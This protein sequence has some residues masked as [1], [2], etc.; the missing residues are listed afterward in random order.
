MKIGI[1][2]NEVLRDFLGQ[3]VYT[4]EKYIGEVDLKREDIKSTDLMEFFDFETIDGLNKFLFDEAALEIFG[5]A[6]QMSDNLMDKFNLFL[7]DIK[8][9]EEHEIEIVSREAMKSIPSTFFFLSK[10]SCKID[11][12][13]FIVDYDKYWD[14]VDVLITADPRALEVKPEGKMS[15]KINAP[16]N[17]G[18]KSDFE[19]DSIVDFITDEDLRDKILNTKITT[20]E[21]IE[22]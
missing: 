12:I 19:L 20:Y 10:L 14:G 1:S 2:L 6:D 3:F 17:H 22:E 8:D 16:Y 15:I 9:D 21:E 4:Y 18:V 7:M 11:K 13:R 5:H